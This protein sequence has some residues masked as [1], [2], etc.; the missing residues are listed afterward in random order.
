MIAKLTGIVDEIEEGQVVLD[1]LGI[2]YEVLCP[3]SVLSAL[4]HGAKTTLYTQMVVR[5]DS[6]TLFGFISKND[7][8]WFNILTT[9]QGVG[10]KV[11]LAIMSIL[12]VSQI[13]SAILS[14]DYKAFKNV[15]GIGNKLA[16]RIVNELKTKKEI[17]LGAT[18]SGSFEP[19]SGSK[20]NALAND[21]NMV[22]DAVLALANLGFSRSDAFT[23]AVKIH[24]E[25]SNIDLSDLIKQCLNR[26]TG[27]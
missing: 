13:H 6:L 17:A 23:H 9:V 4:S 10:P 25:N 21:N 14:Q 11:G 26:L 1:V 20:N 19:N 16:E 24:A 27:N 3:N 12:S 2:G 5:E 8:E 15:S 18:I 22:N 7:K